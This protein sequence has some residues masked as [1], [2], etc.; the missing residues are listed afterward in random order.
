[1]RRHRATLPPGN[2]PAARP[3]R[4]GH[5]PP[6]PKTRPCTGGL[7][8]VVRRL[9]A[10]A[11]LRLAR[12]AGGRERQA[13][14]RPARSSRDCP[15]LPEMWTREAGCSPTGSPR[16]RTHCRW[17]RCL[18][19]GRAAILC[20]VTRRGS[21]ACRSLS[22]SAFRALMLQVPFRGRAAAR[23]LPRR[24]RLLRRQQGTGAA[25]DGAG[26]GAPGRGPRGASFSGTVGVVLLCRRRCSRRT[27]LRGTRAP[28]C[29]ARRRCRS[30][31]QT[32]ARCSRSA[33]MKG[34]LG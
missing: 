13:A 12:A 9:A 17:A 2:P 14:H 34:D 11:A 6:T 15:R 21:S 4:P 10:F 28:R 32:W 26:G 23:A 18:V 24:R 22:S 25:I 3:P 29:W 8:G 27:T 31:T 16:R 5:A 19:C 30:A 33:A 20:Q 7:G 1:M